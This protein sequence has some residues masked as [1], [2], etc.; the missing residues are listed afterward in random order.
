V[1][2]DLLRTGKPEQR[3]REYLRAL[4]TAGSELK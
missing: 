2:S 3:V 1:I 4:N